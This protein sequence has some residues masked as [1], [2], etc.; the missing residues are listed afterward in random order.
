MRALVCSLG[1]ASLGVGSHGSG[2]RVLGLRVRLLA[3]GTGVGWEVS[4]V[5][6]GPDKKLLSV[7]YCCMLLTTICGGSCYKSCRDVYLQ[8][9]SERQTM[10]VQLH[11]LAVPALQRLT[12]P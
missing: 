3:Y 1:L 9:L 6:A 11:D 12:Q 8:V 5:T 2:S 4:E 10:G 7:H